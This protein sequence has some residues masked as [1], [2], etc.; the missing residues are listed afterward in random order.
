VTFRNLLLPEDEDWAWHQPGLFVPK[1]LYVSTGP[2]DENLRYTFD[3]EWLCRLTQSAAVIYLHVLVAKF[4][5]HGMAKTTAEYPAAMREG[6]QV[7][8]RYWDKIPGLDRPYRRALQ[9]VRLASVY[10]GYQPN[11]APFWDRGA[12]LRHLLS[13]WRRYP[14]IIF[15]S[16]FR[17]LCLR[18]ILPKCLLRSSPWRRPSG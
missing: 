11:Y 10:L 18:T 5:V 16:D 8:R 15:S 6:H 4:R 7:I 13:T 12:G 9:G 2:L 3:Y 14:R 17:S 1:S